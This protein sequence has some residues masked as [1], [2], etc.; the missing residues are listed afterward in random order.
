[1]DFICPYCDYADE[2]YDDLEK[3]TESNKI[4]H[5]KVKCTDCEKEFYLKIEWVPELVCE[6]KYGPH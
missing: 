6:V 4:F 5:H 2:L 1:M 3:I